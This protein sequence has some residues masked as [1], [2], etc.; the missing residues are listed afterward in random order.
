MDVLEEKGGNV[1]SVSIYMGDCLCHYCVSDLAP[2]KMDFQASPRGGAEADFEAL[3]PIITQ[4]EKWF[5][6]KTAAL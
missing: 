5:Q 1:C 4:Y 6:H 3:I 2:S